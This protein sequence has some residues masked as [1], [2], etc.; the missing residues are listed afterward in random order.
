MRV[1]TLARDLDVDAEQI[2]AVCGRIG[3]AVRNKL[4][5]LTIA[6]CEAIKQAIGRG[7]GPDDDDKIPAKLPRTP[8][9]NSSR[10]PLQK[11]T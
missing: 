9:K 2:V 11:P 10:V 4:T 1:C 7:E 3:I 5:S 6:Q 8:P